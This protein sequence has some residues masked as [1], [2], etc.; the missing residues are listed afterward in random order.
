M[1]NTQTRRDPGI[2]AVLSF[3]VTGLGQIYNGEIGKGIL[4]VVIQV[5]N[6]FL[7]FVLIGLITSPLVWIYGIYD[8]HQTATES[9]R[10][11]EV[12]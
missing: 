12:A 1:Q 2:A 8:A 7:C 9:G 6:F 3:L 10:R 4:L 11:E 5:I